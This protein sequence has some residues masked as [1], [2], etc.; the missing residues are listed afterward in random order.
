MFEGDKFADHPLVQ[1]YYSHQPFDPAKAKEINFTAV[2]VMING[3]GPYLAY[4]T[5]QFAK[6][7]E[8]TDHLFLLSAPEW[9]PK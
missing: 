1:D 6:R 2:E 5:D 7:N 3:K 8:P 9:P 4:I